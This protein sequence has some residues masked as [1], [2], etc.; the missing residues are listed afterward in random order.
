MAGFLQRQ[1]PL[2]L[3]RAITMAP[4]LLVLGPR[5]R[6]TAALV[7]SQVVLSFGIPF[8]LVPLVLLTRGPTSWGRWSTGRH[9]GAAWV[10]R[11]GHRA[12]RLPADRA[13]GLSAGVSARR[14]A[15]CEASYARRRHCCH[16]PAGRMPP[17]VVHGLKRVRRPSGAAARRRCSAPP[18]AATGRAGWRPAARA[19]S[20]PAGRRASPALARQAPRAEQQAP[21]ATS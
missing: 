1:I 16:G 6:P 21:P 4:A 2:L 19:R 7:L 20:G 18:S 15:T 8:A 3:G 14:A 5:H 10:V 9:D 12:E 13:A 11:P 17:P